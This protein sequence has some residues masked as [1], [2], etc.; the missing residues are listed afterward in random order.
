MASSVRSG[1]STTK[2]NSD[3]D[4][5]A[6]ITIQASSHGPY[7]QGRGERISWTSEQI[8]SM[9]DDLQYWWKH[10]HR[11]QYNQLSLSVGFTSPSMQPTMY[12]NPQ[13]RGTTVC[14]LYPQMV[15]SADVEPVDTEGQLLC[16]QPA[17]RC[18]PLRNTEVQGVKHW[19]LA[20]EW[21]LVTSLSLSRWFAPHSPAETSRGLFSAVKEAAGVRCLSPPTN[22]L[23]IPGKTLSSV[24]RVPS[25]GDADPA[26]HCSTGNVTG[27]CYPG[28]Y[29]SWTGV[30]YW[31]DM[32]I[33]QASFNPLSV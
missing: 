17:L 23:S 24:P 30:I 15:Q 21:S 33:I 32:I 20:G 29:V 31:Y 12:Q 16:V 13:I 10:N 4:F 8:G 14:T 2:N 27:Q 11:V 7:I 5:S 26:P 25:L 22:L 6:T 19:G 1:E 3:Q 9:T 28:S 18:L